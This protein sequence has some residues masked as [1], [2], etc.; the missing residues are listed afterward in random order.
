MAQTFDFN[1]YKNVNNNLYPILGIGFVVLFFL[2]QCFIVINPGERGVSVTLGNVDRAYRN[3]GVNFKLPFLENVRVYS[4]KQ[5]TSGGESDAFSSDLQ[6][7]KINFTITYRIQEKQLVKLIT[8][9]EGDPFDKLLSPRLQSA[10]KEVAATFRAEDFVKNR[11]AVQKDIRTRLDQNLE[12]LIIVDN[13]SITN[14]DLSDELEKAIEQKQIMEQQ[15][16]AKRYELEKAKRE[17]EI[18][19]VNANAEAQA[20][21]IKGQAL[22]S[23]PAVIDLEIAKKWDGKSPSTVVTGKGGANVLLPL[24]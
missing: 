23:S 14:I 16:L 10:L 5:V 13:V 22:K 20:V 19:V 3:E 24:R 2:S 15:A 9:Y 17:A 7:M 1:Q 11:N 21:N 8:G 4:V 12:S 6:N 18:T